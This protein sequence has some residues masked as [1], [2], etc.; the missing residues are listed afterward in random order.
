[1]Y[2]PNDCVILNRTFT[3]YRERNRQINHINID[4]LT[5]FISKKAV[6]QND[7]P[8]IR[9]Y[10]DGLLLVNGTNFLVKV[11]QNSTCIDL[12]EFT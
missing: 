9:A 1:M 2:S 11:L 8:C 12:L 7:A 6:M 5:A 4:T 3:R 10:H